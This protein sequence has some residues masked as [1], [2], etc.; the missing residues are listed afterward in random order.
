[1]SFLAF[2]LLVPLANCFTQTNEDSYDAVFQIYNALEKSR[3]SEQSKV[4]DYG[5]L[6]CTFWVPE[7]DQLN[8][9]SFDEGFIFLPNNIVLIVE[10]VYRQIFEEI[11]N[12]GVYNISFLKNI[13]TYEM[14]DNKIS[15]FTGLPIMYLENNSLYIG[16]DLGCDNINFRKYK[17]EQK[18]NNYSGMSLFQN[19]SINLFK[20]LP[21]TKYSVVHSNPGKNR[22]NFEQKTKN[23]PGTDGLQSLQA[24][25]SCERL[26][27]KVLFI[28]GSYAASR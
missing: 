19:R 13:W 20:N 21:E 11:P 26:R 1:M 28:R 9:S 8:E 15:V 23:L 25:L 3:R 6:E 14:I 12:G 22:R 16:Y 5:D 24:W 2:F 17:F 10:V 7:I 18:F 4:E 27:E